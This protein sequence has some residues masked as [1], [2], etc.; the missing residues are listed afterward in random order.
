MSADAYRARPQRVWIF[1][2]DNTLH[3]AQPRVFPHISRAMTAY[4][5]RALALHEDAANALRVH[6]WRRYGATLLG[7]MR[8]HPHIKPRQFLQHTHLLHELHPLL[9]FDA[10][11]PGLLSA[12]PG[13]KILLSNAPEHY[14]RAVLRALGVA[15]FFS[16]VL[17]MESLRFRPKPAPHAF[18][19]A[20]LRHGL[21]PGRAIMV[22]DDLNNL[23]TAKRLGMRTVWVTK[24][25]KSPRFV[26]VRVK[27][28]MRLRRSLNR[29]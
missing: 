29:L 23:R 17:C 20:L 18:R 5:Q 3:D 2:L 25:S 14:A 27:S 28:V 13:K 24:A 1:D 16:D 21:R 22:D 7:V 15:K 26:D 19:Q 10:G 9:E 11:L 6:Y 4:L 8:H 12:L